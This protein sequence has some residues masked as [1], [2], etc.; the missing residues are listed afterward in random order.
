[1]KTSIIETLDQIEET[2]LELIMIENKEN[3]SDLRNKRF[4]AGELKLKI[5]RLT[6]EFH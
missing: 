5:N 2:E 4:L 3:I 1:M 6:E